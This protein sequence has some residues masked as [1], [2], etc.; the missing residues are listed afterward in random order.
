M[1]GVYK[2]PLFF[3]FLLLVMGNCN[4][5]MVTME[6]EKEEILKVWQQGNEALENNDWDSY[7]K[8]WAHSDYIQIIH[9]KEK[10]WLQGWDTIGPSY[11][12][13]IEQ[14]TDIQTESWDVEIQVSE[15][16]K[17]AWLTCKTKIEMV[18][19][20]TLEFESWQTNIFEKIEGEWKLVH[21]HASNLY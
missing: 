11:K 6:E 5:S 13:F 20:D 3:I 15:G 2:H 17:M 16:A 14:G 7:S 12:E 21:G 9:P 8:Y 10:E 18:T 4:Q 19:E 1:V